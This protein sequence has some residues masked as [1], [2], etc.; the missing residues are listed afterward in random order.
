MLRV[1]SWNINGIRSPLQGLTCQGPS[2]CPTAL[3]RILD[4]LDADIVCLQETKVTRD[5]LTEPLAVVEGYNSYFS[6]SRSRSGYSGVATFCKDS[7]TPVAAEEGLS[8]V[9]A[10]QNGDVGCYG[11]MDEFTQEE[12]RVLDSEGRAVLTQHKIRTLEGKEKTLILIN[13]YCPHADP[14][15]PERLTFKMRFYRLLQIR[16]EALL[17]AGSHVIILGDLNTAH[18]PIDHCDAGSLECFEEDPGRKWMDGLLSSPGME[19]GS[20]TGLFMDSYRWFHPKQE[21]AFTC[22]SVVSGARHLNYGSR[23]DYVLGDRS[24]VIDTFQSSFLLPDVMGSDHCPVGAVLTVSCVPAKQCPALCTRFLPEFAGTQLK[25]LRFLVPLEQE[26][27]R[28]QTVLQPSHQIQVQK[29]P[30][31]ARMH[32]TR[33][34]K[35]QGVSQR[36]QKNLMSYFQPSSSLPQPSPGVELPSL[37][38]VGPLTIPETPEKVTVATVVED[39]VKDSEA[40]NEKEVRTSFWKSMLSGPSP[41]PLCGGHREP[42]V[43]RTVKKAG[44]NLGRQFYMCARPRGPPSDPAARCNFFLWS[45]PS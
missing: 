9:F 13:V 4:K 23:L 36:N 40:K 37:P 35:S 14:G 21:R 22:W 17:A 45:R 11:N 7:A 24:L 38:L 16:A 43:M 8:G 26:P 44:P 19:A 1:V 18:R 30:S 6:F 31:K 39:K 15:R 10:T 28:V 27:V 33:P 32:S 29:H 2:N 25:I 3:R 42:C 12:L 20:H 5:V 41:M 34:R